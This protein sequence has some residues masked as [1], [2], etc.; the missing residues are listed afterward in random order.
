MDLK[1]IEELGAMD[2]YLDL[3]KYIE[4]FINRNYP[5]TKEDM[6]SIVNGKD[7]FNV[8]KRKEVYRVMMSALSNILET[9]MKKNEQFVKGISEG[10][11]L[12]AEN[13]EQYK[14]NLFMYQQQILEHLWQY[15][16]NPNTIQTKTI[17]ENKEYLTDAINNGI[18]GEAV[19]STIKQIVE[20]S[21]QTGKTP[22]QLKESVE[23]IASFKTG[24]NESENPKYSSEFV[25]KNSNKIKSALNEGIT[26]NE[27]VT[28][29]T[30][31]LDNPKKSK[32]NLKFITRFISKTKRKEFNLSN[33]IVNTEKN[34]Q[35]V[36]V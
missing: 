11:N 4:N 2:Y 12:K 3:K 18:S 27:I 24:I 25:R 26:P 1:R 16:N 33:N 22:R 15:N 7:S 20:Q 30:N 34:R 19:N 14:K 5:L 28:G 6:A 10:K 36:K 32:K 13:V 35:K 21:D 9:I 29:L 23:I 17:F 8:S 31:S